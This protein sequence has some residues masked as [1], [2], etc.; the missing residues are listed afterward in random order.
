[1]Y[2]HIFIYTHLI[3]NPLTLLHSLT[4]IHTHAYIYIH[5]YIYVFT[6][7]YP[8]TYICM[9][10]YI[11]SPTSSSIHCFCSAALYIYIYIHICIYIYMYIYIYIY[12]P[13]YAFKY[14]YTYIDIY[15]FTYIYSHT[16]SSI[17][18]FCSAALYKY[19]YIYIYICIYIYTYIHMYVFT[20]I[21]IHTPHHQSVVSAPQPCVRSQLAHSSVRPPLHS[22]YP[23]PL[24][25]L[26]CHE[27]Y[28]TKYLHAF[29][30]L[31]FGLHC[32]PLILCL[33]PLCIVTNYVSRTTYMHFLRFYSVATALHLS[34][35]SCLSVLSRTIPHELHITTHM[36]YPRFYCAVPALHLSSASR[37]STFVTNY[38]S[39]LTFLCLFTFCLVTNDILL[40]LL[41]FTRQF[42]QK[43]PALSFR[44]R[45][46]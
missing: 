22:T 40:P 3:I 16:S 35:A 28:V 31:L 6:Y 4:S 5:I 11:Y 19:I 41:I 25:S 45:A 14:I 30:A 26:Y 42:S 21:Y 44:K 20:Y 38:M 1:M 39:R 12:I 36:H 37:L 27:L 46:L 15:A 7:I 24:A 8:Y 10:I 32:T 13:I 29:P 33:L 43:S 23:L 17:R 2:L 34:S 18:C 9:Y